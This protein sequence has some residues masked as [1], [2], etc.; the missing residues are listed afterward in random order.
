MPTLRLHRPLVLVLAILASGCTGMQ[1]T[2]FRESYQQ[3]AKADDPFLLPHSGQPGFSQVDDMAER[4]RAMHAEGFVM[5]GY[6]QFVSP[7]LTT[8]AESYSTK[9]GVEVGAAHVVLETPRPGASNLH[10][11]LVTY[12]GRYDA[13]AFGIGVAW[14]DLPEDLLKRI[15][16]DKN[17]VMVLQVVPGT[18]AAAAGLRVGDVVV[19]VD[20]EYVQNTTRLTQKIN[21]AQGKEVV[22]GVSRKGESLELPVRVA[23]P[24]RRSGTSTVRY[25]EAPWLDTDPRD[26]SAL[27]VASITAAN[28]A[29]TKQRIEQDRQ[30]YNERLRAQALRNQQALAAQPAADTGPT[31]RRGGGKSRAELRKGE[32]SRISPLEQQMMWKRTEEWARDMGARMDRQ[33]QLAVKMWLE[34]AQNP[35]RF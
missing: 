35:Y 2:Y 24:K 18:P 14:Q 16:E 9:W 26:W 30:L 28:M 4:A 33:R 19:E 17:L 8:L 11:Y 6:S 25:L 15:G 7:L 21:E 1:T 34:N 31:D 23:T 5:Q 27:S 12:W 29:A 13:Q 32:V 3:L 20:G 22:L 10:S